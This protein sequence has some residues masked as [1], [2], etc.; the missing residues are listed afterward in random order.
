MLLSAKQIWANHQ[1]EAVIP[2]TVMNWYYKKAFYLQAWQTCRFRL[3]APCSM[4]CLAFRRPSQGQVSFQ[5]C[6][7][8]LVHAEKWAW[9]CWHVRLPGNT[10]HSEVRSYS[11]Q[12]ITFPPLRSICLNCCVQETKEMEGC[13]VGC[14]QSCLLYFDSTEYHNG[15]RMRS[16]ILTTT[17]DCWG[18]SALGNPSHLFGF[19]ASLVAYHSVQCRP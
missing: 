2:I 6:V 1:S 14:G 5:H 7:T 16:R 17:A 10:S 4:V 12:A 13:G 11:R 15:F 18:R 3:I 8:V 19:G 9:L